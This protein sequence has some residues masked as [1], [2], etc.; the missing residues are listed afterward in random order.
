MTV[1]VYGLMFSAAA[2]MALFAYP[3]VIERMRAY[4]RERVSE[5]SFHLEDMFL[6]WSSRRLRRV[7]VFAP[8]VLGLAG[9]LVTGLWP[10]GL[11]GAG[12]GA[13]V[14]KLWIQHMRRQR[15]KKFHGQL[16]DAL[17]LLSSCLRAGL[18]MMQAFNVVAEEMPAP[19]SQE[20]GLVL[21][22]TR[23]GV[24]FDEAMEHFK[25]RA[26][27]DDSQLFV[28][29]ILVAR[30]TGGDITAVFTRLVETLRERNKIRERIKTLTFM[31]KLQGIMMGLLPIIFVF[32]TYTMDR[33]HF[34]FFL[35][36]DLGRVIL[37]GIVV[38]QVFGGYLFMR[39]S[40]SPL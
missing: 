8:V 5:A 10:I 17:M 30:E 38:A 18:S 4:L 12:L 9:W 1:V 28:T 7:Y 15:A 31:A 34:G 16:V 11:I 39:F 24:G 6:N 35:K 27:S 19:I 14:P 40:R 13:V 32:V 25:Q 29:A 23:M 36:D 21:K 33:N 26:P 37:A 22:E 20:F 2:L 3:P